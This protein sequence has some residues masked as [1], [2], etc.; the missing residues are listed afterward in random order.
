MLYGKA[1]QKTDL[2]RLKDRIYTIYLLKNAKANRPNADEQKNTVSSHHWF[3]DSDQ[4][5]WP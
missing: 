4:F 5:I 2:E 1:K 3:I